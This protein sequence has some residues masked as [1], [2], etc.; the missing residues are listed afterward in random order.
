VTQRLIVVGGDAAGMSAASQAKRMRKDDLEVV[1]LER[2][3]Y[4]SYSACG[5]PYWVG[6]EVDGDRL[7][8]R[9]PEQH[10]ANGID[11][12]MRI[13]VESVDLDTQ[14]IKTR[15]VDTGT[16]GEEGFDHLVIATGAEPIRPDL[17]GI[18]AVGIFGLQTLD[19]GGAV[20]DYLNERNPKRVVV[21]GGG[22]IGIEMAE[23]MA[24]RGLSVTV[25][26]QAK[27]PMTTLDPDMGRMV[28]EA[29]EGMGIDVRTACQVDGFA[30][31]A[32]GHIEAVSVNGTE[33]PADIVICGLGVKPNTALAKA[34][35]LRLG[36]K[37]GLRTDLR[38]RVEGMQNVWAGGDCVESRNLVSEDWVHAP[39]GTHANKQGRVI[40]TNL[41]GGY[42]T[43]PGVVGTAMSKV[44]NLEIARTGLRENEAED[45]G[46][47][48]VTVIHKS[49]TRAGYYPETSPITV[50]L[51]AELRT[52][53]LLGGQIVGR[54][55]GAAKRIDTLAVALWNRMTVEEI[56]ALDLGYA[57]PFSPVWDPVLIAARKAT[58][59]VQAGAKQSLARSSP[60][61]QMTGPGR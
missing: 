45:A 8:A 37:E 20:I 33:M 21:V 34:A 58:E 26:D 1:A 54:S 40:G 11:L 42:A 44:M 22:Y 25:V 14:T 10:R 13:A 38:M 18:D 27:E 6:G 31:A 43:F 57:P 19:D 32:D 4:T 5:I 48:V 55:E 12:R 3:H 23:A 60:G 29:M 2:S 56:T 49:T 36:S 28:H 30:A 52:G 7:V 50:K 9:T 17:P 15:N 16:A 53:R 59:A 47:K 61:R 46:Y 24:N 39:L 35:G 51:I 41:G